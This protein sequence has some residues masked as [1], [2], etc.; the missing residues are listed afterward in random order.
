MRPWAMEVGDGMRPGMGSEGNV[1]VLRIN[2]ILRKFVSRGH[3]YDIM[4][5]IFQS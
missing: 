2:E 1:G 5:K 3:L 4:Q